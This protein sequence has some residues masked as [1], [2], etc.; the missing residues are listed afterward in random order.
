M[1][2]VLTDSNIVITVLAPNPYTSSFYGILSTVKTEMEE[3][4]LIDDGIKNFC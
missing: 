1:N 2:Y 3:I 4:G